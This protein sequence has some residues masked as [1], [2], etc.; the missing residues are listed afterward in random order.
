MTPKERIERIERMQALHSEGKTYAEIG[1]EY[2]LSRQRVEKIIKSEPKKR[3]YSQDITFCTNEK[4]T[5]KLCERHPCHIRW[6]IKPF[7]S[8]ADFENTDYCPEKKKKEGT[9]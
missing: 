3:Y 8:F 4:C 9:K 1:K 5:R 6:D 2:G 7:Q